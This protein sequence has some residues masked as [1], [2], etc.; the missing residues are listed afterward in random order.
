MG[1]QGVVFLPFLASF[2]T[3][4]CK[5]C[6]R[7]EGLWTTHF[8]KLCLG[9]A[10]SCSKKNTRSLTKPLLCQSNVVEIIRLLDR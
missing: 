2:S 8:L 1:L 6:S 9:Q 10:S 3:T 7:C 4:F 5:H